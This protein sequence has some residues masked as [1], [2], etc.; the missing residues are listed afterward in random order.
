MQIDPLE[1]LDRQSSSGS[2]ESAVFTLDPSTKYCKPK[3]FAHKVEPAFGRVYDRFSE[4]ATS[5]GA[6]K[7]ITQASDLQ[8][9][10]LDR[11]SKVSTIPCR[12]L[13]ERPKSF[14]SSVKRSILLTIDKMRGSRSAGSNA[15][16]ELKSGL[17]QPSLE[18]ITVPSRS[19]G[20]PG[21]SSSTCHV[22]DKTKYVISDSKIRDNTNWNVSQDNFS[23]N[24]VHNC[25][26]TSEPTDNK[27]FTSSN[28]LR[29]TPLDQ[30]SPPYLYFDKCFTEQQSTMFN[31]TDQLMGLDVLHPNMSADFQS[32]VDN[33]DAVDIS[34]PRE[35]NEDLKP[36]RNEF[37]YHARRQNNSIS[38]S[39]HTTEN[40]SP[41]LTSSITN[42]DGMSPYHLPQPGT[43][44]ISEFGDD[45]FVSEYKLQDPE[46]NIEP[47]KLSLDRLHLGSS[48]NVHD[49]AYPGFQG[50]S[51]PKT[52]YESALTLRKLPSNP[53]TADCESPFKN[54]G[55]KDLIHSWNDDGHHRI[56]QL[57]E[58]VDDLGYL[59]ELI[60]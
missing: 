3:P 22:N 39:Y 10:D 7:F 4:S 1:T 48:A 19:P 27:I 41:G 21:K 46:P 35:T 29:N 16:Q 45:N 60:I 34:I 15:W 38:S 52:E 26:K 23:R 53:L 55:S 31:A 54:Q 37:R 30:L 6:P 13:N 5:Q 28:G 50:Y 42:T 9:D 51:L 11:K 2:I 14:Q 32:S 20:D 40:F 8:S 36:H 25:L 17:R 12:E 56:S 59:G 44:S 57:N 43:P 18:N 33:V 47:D 49:A 58:L 24:A